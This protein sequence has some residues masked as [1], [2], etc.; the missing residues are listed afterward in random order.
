MLGSDLMEILKRNEKYNLIPTDVDTLD[1]TNIEELK[2]TSNEKKPD[3]VINV[4]A[5]T[6]VDGCETNRELAYNVNAIGPK[7]LAISCN[8]IGA[9]LVHI[10]TDYVFHGENTV[11]YTEED[12][13]DPI[14][15][16]GE[17]KL[18]AEQFIQ[19]NMNSY[20]TN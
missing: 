17:T 4:A 3:I 7:N 2:E 12:E 5:Y 18:V 6:D 1:I 13:T 9:K 14:N 10:S 15:Y 16:Y 8:E 11:P 20:L 19:K